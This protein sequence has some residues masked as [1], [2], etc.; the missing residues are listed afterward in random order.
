MPLAGPRRALS[1]L[2]IVIAE[3]WIHVNSAVFALLARTE[4]DVRGLD[5]LSYTR[6]YLVLCNH[7]SWVDIPVLQ[8]V[9]TGRIPF[10][11]FFLKSQLIW[12]PF[13]GI[14]WWA[15]DFP[16]M[17]RY[18]RQ[19]LEKRPEL[20]GTDII[21]TRKA[22]AKFRD[23]PVSV[24]NFVEGTRFTGRKHAAQQSP[25]T[26]LLKP[27]SGGVAFVL[28]AMGD[29]LH[30][31]VDVTLRYPDAVGIRQVASRITDVTRMPVDV[32]QDVF[33]QLAAPAA[34][35]GGGNGT[36]AQSGGVPA[37]SGP[38]D[39]L[40][41]MD[42]ILVHPSIDP[43]IDPSVYQSNDPCLPSLLCLLS[44]TESCASKERYFLSI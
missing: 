17:K 34:T 7:Q 32:S 14:A 31:V 41:P 36:Q 40:I 44:C 39:M 37:R 21:A 26:H 5:G 19:Q 3:S 33:Q 15:L 25:Y 30:A 12:V 13:L 16:F 38:G 35:A 11:R 4:W 6:S 1:R 20:R 22:C 18:T 27:K 10:L 43:S 23:M 24:M 42:F 28:D 29:A 9:L 8:K 2:L